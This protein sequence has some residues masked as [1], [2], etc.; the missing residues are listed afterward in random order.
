MV[1]LKSLNV[2]S[3]PESPDLKA[4]A[5]AEQISRDYVEIIKLEVVPEIFNEYGLKL[6]EIRVLMTM[7]ASNEPRSAAQ[8]AEFLRQDPA[9]I[10]RS[11]VSL[12]GGKFLY[13]SDDPYDHRIKNLNLTD[14]GLTAAK[15]CTSLF[16][17]AVTRL[18]TSGG[19]EYDTESMAK[20][21]GFFSVIEERTRELLMRARR[22]KKK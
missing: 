2:K 13:S 19:I 1:T 9:T 6:R 20:A 10:T 8:L 5:L 15:K 4:L 3:L 14:K 22:L 17:A 7:R 11:S 16:E 21:S 12:I 18:Q